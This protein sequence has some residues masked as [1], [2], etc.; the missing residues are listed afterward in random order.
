MFKYIFLAAIVAWFLLSNPK[1]DIANFIWTNSS[2]PWEKVDGYYYPDKNTTIGMEKKEAV[3][4]SDDCK[5]WAELNAKAHQDKEFNRGK[6]QC[7][8]G[9]VKNPDGTLAYRLL[10]PKGQ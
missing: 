10:L 4:D 1:N 9:Q 6:Y 8:V 2:A 3:G 5:D 7:G